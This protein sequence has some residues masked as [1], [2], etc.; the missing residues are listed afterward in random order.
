MPAHVS[1]FFCS[2]RKSNAAF[3]LGVKVRYSLGT[4]VTHSFFKH[5]HA[6]I[7][8]RCRCPGTRSLL[9]CCFFVFLFCFFFLGGGGRLIFVQGIFWVLLDT[10]W[11]FFSGGGGGLIFVRILSAFEH[12]RNLES[13]VPRPLR[14]GCH[15]R[16]CYIQ[17]NCICPTVV[18]RHLYV[19]SA[20]N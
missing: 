14:T 19:T 18:I 7:R 6:R 11:I 1:Y 13:G 2:T 20:Q 8:V 9:A 12:P 10:L 15:G 17:N 3:T 4:N 16:S 5:T